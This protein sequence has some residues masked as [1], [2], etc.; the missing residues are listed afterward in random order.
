MFCLTC[1]L[2]RFL[3]YNN[4]MERHTRPGFESDRLLSLDEEDDRGIIANSTPAERLAM[5]WPI[6]ESCWALVPKSEHHAE[7]EFQRHVVCVR[8]GRG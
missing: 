1:S 3:V 2:Q 7:P 4:V 5:V 8:R 6:T